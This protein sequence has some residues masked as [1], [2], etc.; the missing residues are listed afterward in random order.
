MAGGW[1]VEERAGTASELH[2]SWP[3]VETEPGVR[4]VAVCRVTAPAVVLGSTQPEGVVDLR[5]AGAAGITV[6]R[7]RSGGGAVLVAEDDP[8]WVDVWVPSG[9]ELWHADVG[10]AFDW[11]GAAWARALGRIGVPGL[12]VHRKGPVAPTRWAKL[13]CFG[14]VGSGEVITPEGRKVVGLAQR[15]NREG[16]WFHGACVIRWDPVPLVT[17]LDIPEGER[18][19]AASALAVAAVGV[20][21]L[22]ERDGGTAPDATSIVSRLIAELP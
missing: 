1:R 5:R 21:D 8:V 7:R 22:A 16:V 12:S 10:R 14:G 9:D 17:V 19:E 15:R 4:A 3:G 18:H 2:G 20:A 13:V 11:L 6:A